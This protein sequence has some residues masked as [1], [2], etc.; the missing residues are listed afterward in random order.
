MA[1]FKKVKDFF[2]IATVVVSID[3]ADTFSAE[4]STIDGT[5]TVTGKSDQEVTLVKIELREHWRTGSGDDK[6]EKHFDLGKQVVCDQPFSIKEGEERKFPFSM[7]FSLIRS[8]NDEMAEQ[9]GVMGALG[10]VGA[11]LD[12]E[13]STFKLTAMADVK[14]ATFDP[15]C[16]K[17]L[18]KV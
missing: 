11:F 13:K 16:E 18:K 6:T 5:I 12:Q 1:F 15:N 2:G 14:A 10:K 17:V 8:K 9:G 4:Q 3:T 7:P